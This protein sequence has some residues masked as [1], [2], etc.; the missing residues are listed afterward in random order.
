MMNEVVQ[1]RA[2]ETRLRFPQVGLGTAPLGGLYSLIPEA[3]ALATVQT[4]LTQGWTLFDTAPLYGAGDSERRL[5][6][7]LADV[8]RDHYQVSTKVGRSIESDGSVIFDYSQSGIQRS[9][10]ESLKRLK[11]DRVDILHLHDPDQH[12]R[13]ALE[14]ALP[15][16]VELRRQGV[17]DAIGVGMNQWEML[18]DLTR[19]SDLDC[20]LLAGRYTLLE[21]TALP[22]LELCQ[23][24]CVQVFL[25]SVY[26]S[27]I[28]A[29]GAQP[30]ATYNYARATPAIL[31]RVRQLETIAA[32]Y[33]VPLRAV[34]LQF[35]AAHPAVTTLIN[36]ARSP[37]EIS[38]TLSAL[39][40][41][42]PASLWRDLKSAKLLLPDSPTP[43]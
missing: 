11:L 13:E 21:Q 2:R 41:P 30:E 26:N 43:Q 16:L 22:L 14:V 32:A 24:R 31:E 8:P 20:V 29:T 7:A 17:I 9:F 40:F 23:A 33:Q 4:A 3:Q 38:E 12:Y 37:H 6:A 1:S 10:E 19:H 34:A 28:L 42:I 27:G 39:A 18:A 25:G 35:A 36:G 5:G 15:Q